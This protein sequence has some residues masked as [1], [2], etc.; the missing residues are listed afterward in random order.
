MANS[1]YWA[2]EMK[3]RR[4]SKKIFC[5]GCL[6]L[7]TFITPLLQPISEIYMGTVDTSTWNLPFNIA[8]PFNMQTIAGWLLTW[9]FQVNVSLAFAICMILMT[10]G[11]VGSC[12]YI[13]SMC[14][15]FEL[16]I[17][18]MRLDTEQ[19]MWLNVKLKL[20]QAIERHIDIYE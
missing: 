16:L 3:Y 7:S 14:K 12:F 9:F 18:S 13:S 10:I 19:K 15:H 11:F 5:Y 4:F 8:S 2:S 17:N 6:Q 1:M 20:Q